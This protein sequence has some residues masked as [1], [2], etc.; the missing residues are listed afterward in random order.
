MKIRTEGIN[1]GRMTK[2]IT[3]SDLAQLKQYETVIL[4]N[5]Q[6]GK[7]ALEQGLKNR[8]ALEFFQMLKFDKCV[9]EPLSGEPENLIEVVNQGMTYIVSLKAVEYLLKKHSE[10]SFTVNWGN[11]SGYDIESTDGLIIGECFAATS[12]RSNA[13]HIPMT[14]EDWAKKPIL[15]RLRIYL[16]KTIAFLCFYV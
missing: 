5:L 3:V 12:F 8:S 2:Q 10:K 1:G 15:K 13:R 11:I 4:E 14:M 16:N 7:E 9:V 6:K